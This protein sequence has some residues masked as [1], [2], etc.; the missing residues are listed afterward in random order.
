MNNQINEILSFENI[1]F[2]R[3]G[4]SIIEQVNW[5]I[6]KGEHWGL[7]GLNGAGKS[8][9]LNMIPAYTFPSKGTMRVFGHTFGNYVWERVRQRVGIV[10]SSMNHFLHILNKQTVLEVVLSGKFST[11][12]IYKAINE[13]DRRKALHLL[14]DFEIDHLA[15][16]FFEKLSQGEQRRVLLARA[17]MNDP[18]LLI[19]DEPCSGLDI[20]STEYFLRVLQNHQNKTSLLYVT[21][22]I[23]EIIPKISHIAL[24]GSNGNM[25]ALGEKYNILIDELLTETFQTKVCITWKNQRPWL[26]VNEI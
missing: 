6:K 8:T 16:N 25:L 5:T 19:L 18:E 9:L 15:G 12:G 17:F 13:D 1:S 26:M 23:E 3:E 4:R 24:L 7:L 21:H 22:H 14:D 10:S 11:I 2:I 20:K